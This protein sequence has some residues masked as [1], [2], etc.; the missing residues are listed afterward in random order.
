MK[1]RKTEDEKE[2]HGRTA[3]H[4]RRKAEGRQ[5]GVGERGREEDR[6]AVKG[7]AVCPC[8]VAEAVLDRAR[9]GNRLHSVG[10]ATLKTRTCAA[11]DDAHQE[12][13]MLRVGGKVTVQGRNCNVSIRTRESGRGQGSEEGTTHESTKLTLPTHSKQRGQ[14]R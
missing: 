6:G 5:K 10:K 7:A 2:R 4:G 11:E 1:R 8:S 13:V 14:L 12:P 9:R 3:G